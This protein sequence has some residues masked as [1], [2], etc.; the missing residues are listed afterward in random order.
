MELTNC[1]ILLIDCG[2]Q[3]RDIFC[4]VYRYPTV[5]MTSGMVKK[6]NYCSAMFIKCAADYLSSFNRVSIIMT[7]KLI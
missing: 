2:R 7:L 3:A 6:H 5:K 4:R 1:H